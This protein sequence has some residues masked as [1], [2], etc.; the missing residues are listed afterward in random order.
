MKDL[1]KNPFFYYVLVPAIVALWPLLLWAAFLPKAQEKLE[2]QEKDFNASRKLVSEILKMEPE[3]LALVD[4]NDPG[5]EF[6]YATSVTKFARAAGMTADNY[7]LNSGLR[8]PRRGQDTQSASVS[9]EKV[10]IMQ[11]SGFL[12][13]IQFRW[14]NLECT[15]LALTKLKKNP[16]NWKAEV[17][18]KYY[19]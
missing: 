1:T 18:F 11:I 9:I 13:K 6:D 14:P 19:F 5:A 4:A 15:S 12:E 2:K 7:K 10:K 3:R 16:D 17:K 8:M